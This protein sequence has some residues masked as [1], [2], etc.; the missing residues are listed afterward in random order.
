MKRSKVWNFI[1]WLI[2]ILVAI[3]LFVLA[4]KKPEPVYSVI[5]SPSLI[6]DRENSSPKIKVILE[7]SV[8]VNDNVYVTTIAIWNKGND[9]INSSEIR[10]PFYIFCS[11]SIGQ[12]IDPKI[13]EQNDPDESN[14]RLT[15][16]GDSLKL[17][18][19]YFDANYGCK[20]QIIYLGKDN[21]EILVIGKVNRTK[22]RQVMLTTKE[23]KPNKIIFYFMLVFAIISIVTFWR[24]YFQDLHNK[25]KLW[26]TILYT[27]MFLGML[28]FWFF[29]F[30][31]DIVSTAVPF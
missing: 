29:M 16:V 17:S 31:P 13:I 12:I 26:G 27:L 10:K 1:A 28:A 24:H 25:K 18:W 15:Q 2:P 9:K 22:V 4:D 20:I 11:N 30:K 6:Y 14:F 8:P 5:K 7:D 19:D 23:A 21:T 3:Y